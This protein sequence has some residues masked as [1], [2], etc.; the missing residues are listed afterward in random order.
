MHLFS[1]FHPRHKYVISDECHK[2][3]PVIKQDEYRKITDRQPSHFVQSTNDPMSDDGILIT[4]I[5]AVA[6]ITMLDNDSPSNSTPDFA[7]FDGGSSGGGGASGDWDSSSDSSSS[8]DYSSSSDS[9]SSSDDYSS[10]SDS[11]SSS[12]FSSSDSGGGW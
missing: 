3:L 2:K 10:S 4:E 7:G 9:Y 5:A 6:A 11:S 1:W 12:D 8:S